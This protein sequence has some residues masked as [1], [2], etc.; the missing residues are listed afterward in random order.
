MLS[1]MTVGEGDRVI[2][3]VAAQSPLQ[4][5]HASASRER[6]VWRTQSSSSRARQWQPC[7]DMVRV[8]LPRRLASPALERVIERA[9]FTIAEKPGDLGNRQ[10]PFLQITFGEIISQLIQHRAECHSL[11]LKPPAERSRADAEPSRN[12]C[13]AR[14]P[15]WQ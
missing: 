6:Y 2:A 13:N 5:P 9:R 3:P 14:L 12:L 11:G 1:S 7:D 8:R 4:A 10:R 15:G